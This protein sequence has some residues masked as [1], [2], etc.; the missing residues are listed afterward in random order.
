MTIR[1]S[2]DEAEKWLVAL[3]QWRAKLTSLESQLEA[4]S[5]LTQRFEQVAIYAQGKKN[6]AVLQEV[7][8][9]LDIQQLQL[10]VLKM[11]IQ[12]LES[13][14]SSLSMEE[15]RFVEQK[16]EKHFSN[17]VIMKNLLLTR[18]LFF[19]RRKRIL[20]KIYQF[21]GGPNSLLAISED[22][23]EGDGVGDE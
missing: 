6:E 2:Y 14:I 16:Y 4:V 1:T 3:P 21:V 7:I 22:W 9:R 23:S 15:Q 20:Q 8:R 13:A 10:P 11:K 12:L 18:R 17:E 5:G 19:E